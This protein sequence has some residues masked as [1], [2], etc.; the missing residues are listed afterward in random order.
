MMELTADHNSFPILRLTPQ[1]ETQL[2]R[3]VQEG[4]TNAGQTCSRYPCG[5]FLTVADE[6]L[7][8]LLKDDGQGFTLDDTCCC[9]RP[10]LVLQIMQNGLRV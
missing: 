3:I 1:V 7:T 4:I 6:W 9:W 8:L 5:L 10:F 2:F